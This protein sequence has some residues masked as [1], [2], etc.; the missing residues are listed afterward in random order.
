MYE[1]FY[2]WLYINRNEIK[3]YC[4]NCNDRL[5]ILFLKFTT[6][7]IIKHWKFYFYIILLI[8]IIYC[9]LLF[10]ININKKDKHFLY[11]FNNIFI[12]LY[13][14]SKIKNQN[15]FMK[16]FSD[17]IILFRYIINVY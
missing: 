16:I 3:N 12:Y 6:L 10:T 5:C 15:V 8:N 4:L 17:I 1:N 7:K 14:L 11:I 2:N 9:I 13:F